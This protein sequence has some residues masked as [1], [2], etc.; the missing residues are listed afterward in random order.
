MPKQKSN[1]PYKRTGA[2]RQNLKK[3]KEDGVPTLKLTPEIIYQSI[4]TMQRNEVHP[5]P[6]EN[7]P[8]K[9]SQFSHSESKT[10]NIT[11]ES[12]ESSFDRESMDEGEEQL[13]KCLIFKE[14][15]R[16]WAL[17]HKIPHTALNDL[18]NII[19]SSTEIVN[20]P[21][22]SRTLLERPRKIEVVHMGPEPDGLFWYQGLQKCFDSIPSVVEPIK[23]SELNLSFNIDGLP[24]YKSSKY[25]FWPILAKIEEIPELSPLVLAIY[26]GKCKPDL[27]SFLQ[28]FVEDV[29]RSITNGIKV[30]DRLISIKIRCFICD[31][32]ARAFIKGET[33]FSS[34]FPT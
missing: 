2:Y 20:L 6:C 25:E 24:I 8:G 30:G 19:K 32:P 23:N 10:D 26:Y 17:V 11:V 21:K 14:K 1:L 15:L 7:L 4:E 34:I 29:S 28:D 9:S 22:D 16:N 3:Y 27:K 5:V 18:I 13:E 12:V 31:T 33:N